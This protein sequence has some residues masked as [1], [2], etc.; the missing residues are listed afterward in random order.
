MALLCDQTNIIAQ[1]VKSLQRN[2]S[3][4]LKR[5]PSLSL[6][7]YSVENAKN[8]KATSLEVAFNIW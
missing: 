3:P 4:K 1:R 6:V 5:Q 8:K 2:C 7:D